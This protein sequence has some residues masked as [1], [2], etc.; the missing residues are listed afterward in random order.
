MEYIK[1]LFNKS[2]DYSKKGID[3]TKD[4]QLKIKYA[5]TKW[6]RVLFRTIF[7]LGMGFVMLYPILFMLSS[8]F[9]SVNDVSDFSVIWIPREFSLQPM[10]I[11]IEHLHFVNS[12]FFTLMVVLPSVI[13]QVASTLMVS[14]GFARFR[15]PGQGFLFGLL[16][17]QI[18]VP[19]TAIIIPLY[20]LSFNLG[21]LGTPA[22]LWSMAIAATGLRSALYIFIVRQFFKNIPKEL[23]EAAM[24]DGCGPLKTFARIMVPNVVPAIVTI[25]AFSFVWYWNNF[26]ET[27]MLASRGNTRTLTVALT[28]LRLALGTAG[29]TTPGA[30][31]PAQEEI[32]IMHDAIMAS[33]G[34][35]VVAPL[36]VLY[37]FL[38]RYLT[39]SVEKTGLVG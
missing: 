32:N 9:Q 12:F 13:L 6:A 17:F 33:G 18:I 31:G 21:L 14:Y 27:S 25:T 36:I 28:T 38:Q 2:V 29:E 30:S 3:Y 23:E 24:I 11:A 35:L 10:S 20:V 22:V 15:F 34:L 26:F 39:E 5:S 37:I 16:I 4:N 1:N 19:V 7:L 8:A